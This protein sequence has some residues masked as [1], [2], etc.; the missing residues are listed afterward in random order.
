MESEQIPTLTTVKV[1]TIV[2]PSRVKHVIG[3]PIFGVHKT[4]RKSLGINNLFQ[5]WR[6][7]RKMRKNWTK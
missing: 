6:W 7:K 4:C 5:Y 3:K 2:R 1:E